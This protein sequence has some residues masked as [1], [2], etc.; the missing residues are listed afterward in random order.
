MEPALFTTIKQFPYHNMV[1]SEF[2]KLFFK[3]IQFSITLNNF[4]GQEI[5]LLRT[6]EI[7]K[8]TKAEH[9]LI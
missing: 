4:S 8:C 5:D 6:I 1:L 2:N 9:N 7:T 3:L